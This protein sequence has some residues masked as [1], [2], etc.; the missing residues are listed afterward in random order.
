MSLFLRGL[1]AAAALLLAACGS[2]SSGDAG[3]PPVELCFDASC[4]KRQLVDLPQ[5]ENLHFTADG[6]L[7]VTGQENLYEITRAAD[8]AFSATPKFAGSSG[9]SGV[10]SRAGLLYALCQSGTGPTDFSG[11]V[12]LDLVR[13][14]ALP[15]PI[16][17]LTGMTLPN[18]M[19]FGPD[20][21]LY[22]TDGPIAVAP[23]IVRL[24]VDPVDPRRIVAQEIW[25]SFLLDY[26]NG[27]AVHDRHFYTTLYGSSL[28]SVARIE[29]LDDATAGPIVGVHDRGRIMDDLSVHGDTLLVTDWQAGRI[30]QLSLAGELLHET[31]PAS[32]AQPSAV[33]VGRPPMFRGDEL[34]VTERYTGSGLWMLAPR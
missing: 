22:V 25:Y 15:E 34:L 20:G 32:F 26:P 2:G 27:L 1:S 13:A 18:G 4:V 17:S 3:L 29:L 21:N 11:L 16:F 5:L 31:P 19:T 33:E 9:C 28:G 8:G 24:R 6:R 12:V 14:D 23:K 10:T 30:F 7:F